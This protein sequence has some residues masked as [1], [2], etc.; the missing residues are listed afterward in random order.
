MIRS[1]ITANE[2][3]WMHVLPVLEL[4]HKSTVRS[5]TKASPSGLTDGLIMRPLCRQYGILSPVSRAVLLL[6]AEAILRRARRGR[7]DGG[8]GSAEVRGSEKKRSTLRTERKRLVEAI[9]S[10]SP[11][12]SGSRALSPTSRGPFKIIARTG[13][14]PY[15]LKL[16]PFSIHPVFHVS[17][18]TRK[19]KDQCGP[20]SGGSLRQPIRKYEY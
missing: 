6:Q 8:Q 9:R 12:L 10:P 14:C 15:R 17:L 16:P 5:S 7:A 1:T 13:Q 19:R 4:A 11:G 18:L 2:H 3:H 20:K